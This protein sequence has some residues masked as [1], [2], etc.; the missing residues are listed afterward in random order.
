MTMTEKRPFSEKVD[1]QR[2]RLPEF[3]HTLKE[4]R[5]KGYD[6]VGLDILIGTLDSGTGL[7]NFLFEECAETAKTRAGQLTHPKET[8]KRDISWTPETFDDTVRR[9][10]AD[11]L[12]IDVGEVPL[13]A[14]SA[15]IMIPTETHRIK[16]G[17]REDYKAFIL[18][19]WSENGFP[20]MSESVRTAEVQGWRTMSLEE[21]LA[22]NPD[23]FR[24]C[25]QDIF[26]KAQEEGFFNP[27]QTALRPVS[28]RPRTEGFTFDIRL[29]DLHA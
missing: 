24:P 13:L 29:K 27:Q 3:P 22:G 21:I 7:P 5:E 12:L 6:S 18:V 19:L 16:N 25:T 10:L 14:D 20:W 2:V 8:M 17:V 23:D 9:C 11:E 15:R 26:R 4:L 28:L 1:G